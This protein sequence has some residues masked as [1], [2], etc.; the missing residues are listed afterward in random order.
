[1]SEKSQMSLFSPPSSALPAAGYE[2]PRTAWNG[3][4]IVGEA[5]GAEEIKQGRPFVGR[6][7][8]LLDKALA[9]ADIARAACYVANVFM[10]QPPGNKVDHF[11]LS[12][13]AAHKA[14]ENLREDWGP[15]G[16]KYCRALFAPDVEHMR[17]AVLRE[18]P[19]VLLAAGRTPLWALTGQEGITAAAGGEFPCRFAPDIPVIAVWHPS[20]ILRGNWGL[21]EE[22]TSHMR[23][24]V[25]LPAAA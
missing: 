25:M 1:M 6:S 21:Q 16:G 14:G 4:M 17:A 12:R 5:P 3:I 19:R 10:H 13:R 8:Q 11:F 23:R 24:A 22:W 9:A 15:L 7:G 20:F 2:P 18:K